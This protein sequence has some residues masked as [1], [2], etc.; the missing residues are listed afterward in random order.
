MGHTHLKDNIYRYNA[1]CYMQL[2]IALNLNLTI[3]LVSPFHPKLSHFHCS[4][5]TFIIDHYAPWLA[6]ANLHTILMSTHGVSSIFAI[7]LLQC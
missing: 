4:P 6:E 2:S 3:T 7:V 5:L 1:P